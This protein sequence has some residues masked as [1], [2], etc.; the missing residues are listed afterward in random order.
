MVTAGAGVGHLSGVA[1]AHSNT[2]LKR[3]FSTKKS[4]S[5]IIYILAYS[6]G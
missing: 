5:H 3:C 6:D 4:H 2:P 1:D